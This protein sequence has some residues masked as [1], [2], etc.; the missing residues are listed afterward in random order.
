MCDSEWIHR[1]D[2]KDLVKLNERARTEDK[3]CDVMFFGSSSIRRWKSLQQDMAPLKVVN[4][5][6]GGATLRDLHHN[7]DIVMADYRP[8]CFVIYCDND[9]H[10]KTTQN[11]SVG[12]LFDLYRMLFDRLEA[13]YPGVPVYFLAMKHCQRRETIRDRQNAFN[14][15]MKDYAERSRQVTFVDTCSALL[16]PEGAIDPSLF[17]KDRLHI[18]EQGYQIWTSLLKPMLLKELQN[19]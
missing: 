16:T 9:L 8:K 5:G 3:E 1:Y 17:V 10:T 11:I 18:N 6:Y 13:D 2:E 7:Y 14:I 12:E 4:R 15:V 19:K